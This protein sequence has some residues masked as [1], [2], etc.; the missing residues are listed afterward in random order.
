MAIIELVAKQRIGVEEVRNVFH[1][2]TVVPG[3]NQET[4]AGEQLRTYWAAMADFLHPSWSLYG[5]SYRNIEIA[6]AQ[7]IDV[8]YAAPVVGSNIGELLPAQVA[9]LVSFKTGTTPP[10]QGRKYLAGFTEDNNAVGGVPNAATIGEMQAFATRFVTHN[11]GLELQFNWRIVRKSPETG[12]V[13]AHN[14]ITTAVARR[15]WATMRS[16]RSR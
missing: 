12:L 2:Q 6:G 3:D 14:A 7:S 16:R 9:G 8:D 10:N 5:F 11:A 4:A 1:I 15:F 13:I